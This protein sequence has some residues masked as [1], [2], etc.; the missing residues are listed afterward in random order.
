MI[1]DA[2]QVDYGLLEHPDLPARKVAKGET[3]I[4]Q[5]DNLAAEEMFFVRSGSVTIAVNGKAVE[6]VT[7]GGIFGGA[8]GNVSIRVSKKRNKG[9]FLPSGSNLTFDSLFRSGSYRLNQS[10]VR[11]IR[12][13]RREAG[14][15]MREHRT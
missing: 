1:L 15:A 4:R 10:N 7:R 14:G 8:D 11:M 9:R 2:Q 5:N 13:I 12:S 3:V 6:T